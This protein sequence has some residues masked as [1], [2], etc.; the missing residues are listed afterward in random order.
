MAEDRKVPEVGDE[1]SVFG[2]YGLVTR[3]AALAGGHHEV[4][5]VLKNEDSD[6]KVS[7]PQLVSGTDAEKREREA[8]ERAAEESEEDDA[9]DE[10]EVARKRE[11]DATKRNDEKTASRSDAHAQPATT[12][13]AKEKN[14]R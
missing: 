10:A 13:V 9:E 14:Q 12:R 4:T 7:V 6:V 5:V 8:I 11:E 2:C 3:V 1:C